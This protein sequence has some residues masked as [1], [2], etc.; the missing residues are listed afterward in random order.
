MAELASLNQQSDNGL[1]ANELKS[2]L[3]E[4]SE[5]PGQRG[6]SRCYQNTGLSKVNCVILALKH[7]LNDPNNGKLCIFGHHK[8]VF[9]AIVAQAGLSSKNLILIDMK[10]L[11]Q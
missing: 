5:Q 9:D 3:K 7:F 2:M 4:M 10:S 6:L 1:T 11:P 8:V